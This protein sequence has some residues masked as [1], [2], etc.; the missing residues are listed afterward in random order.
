MAECHDHR[1]RITRSMRNANWFI[2]NDCMFH[3]HFL[4]VFRFNV[5]HVGSLKPNSPPSVFPIRMSLN[6]CL[7]LWRWLRDSAIQIKLSAK[8]D[9][10]YFEYAEKYYI[11]LNVKSIN[12]SKLIDWVWLLLK[13]YIDGNSRKTEHRKKCT[14]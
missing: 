7:Y 11:E 12:I 3:L 6:G 5:C 8:P 10:F 13:F 2:R 4:F 1:N 9:E 14:I